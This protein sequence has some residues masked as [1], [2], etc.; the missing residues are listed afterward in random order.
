MRSGANSDPYESGLCSSL[1]KNSSTFII[2]PR[3]DYSKKT[4]TKTEPNT[5]L[6][7]KGVKR[8]VTG[9]SDVNIIHF[10]LSHPLEWGLQILYNSS[11]GVI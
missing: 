5:L 1:K 4:N 8:S 2:H 11:V 9:L 7:S 6:E 3:L 10:D